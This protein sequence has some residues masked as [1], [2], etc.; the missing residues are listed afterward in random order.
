V[1]QNKYDDPEFFAKYSDMPRSIGGLA[2]A[3][4]WPAFRALL[5]DLRDKR[6]LDLGCGFGW[7]CRYAREEGARSVVGV[8]L[9]EKMLARARETT[10]DPAIEY[11]H[12]AIEDIDFPAGE[13]DVVISSLA[14][15]YVERF[16]LVCRKVHWCLAPGGAFVLSVEHPVFT[17]LATQD[18]HYGPNGERLHWPIDNY[19]DEGLRR[20]RWMADDVVKYHRTVATYVNTLIDSG[21]R[22][23]KLLEP[24]PTPEMLIER[25]AMEDERR[26]PI[27]LLIAAVKAVRMQTSTSHSG[28]A[29]KTSGVPLSDR[30]PVARDELTEAVRFR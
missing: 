20:A 11:R 1:K 17:A 6:L 9:S 4:E 18:W 21:F 10:D 27:F 30:L 28:R 7:H 15:H 23:T 29:R 14:L 5:P 25:P 19:Q 12:S 8:D 16:D 3:G 2:E 26:R 24:E 22:L 13:F